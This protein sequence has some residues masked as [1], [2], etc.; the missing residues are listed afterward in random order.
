MEPRP[1]SWDPYV[2]TLRNAAAEMGGAIKIIDREA[3]EAR[4]KAR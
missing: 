2:M 3:L 1:D 4:K